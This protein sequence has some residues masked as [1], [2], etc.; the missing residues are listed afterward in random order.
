[1]ASSAALA[2]PKMQAAPRLT[3]RV[4][5]PADAAAVDAL[6]EAAFGPGRYAKT[7]ERLREGNDAAAH[8]SV[9]AWSGDALVGAVRLWPIRI[10]GTEALFLGPIA[11]DRAWRRQ[12]LG[13]LLVERACTAAAGSGEGI[14]LL[15]GDAPFFGPLGFF[16]ASGGVDLPGPV[17]RRRLL[18]SELAPGATEGV[19]GGVRARPGS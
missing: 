1:M 8:L 17:D 15:V 3:L 4:E 9:C 2:E 12:G 13:A 6:I 11:V 16:P 19:A 10:G 5:R 14:V 18:W 7:A